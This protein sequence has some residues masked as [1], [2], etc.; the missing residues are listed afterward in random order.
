MV[1]FLARRLAFMVLTMFLLSIAIFAISELAPGNI[2]INTLGNFITPEQ[3]ASFNAQNGLDQP[4]LTRYLRWMVGS[5]WEAERLIGRPIRRVYEENFNRYSW[6]VVA[7]DGTL[8]QNYSP[9]GESMVRVVFQDT[10]TPREEPMGPEVWQPNADGLLVYWGIDTENRAAMWVQGE[11]QVEWVLHAGGTWTD[12]EGAPRA[13]VPLQKGIMRGDPGVSFYTRRPVAETLFSRLINSGYLALL[14]FVF[15]MPLS[16]LLGLVA[17]LNEGKW[18][19]NVLSLGGLITT[20]TP[21]YATGVFLILIFTAWLRLLPG[22]VIVSQDTDIFSNPKMLV[23]PVLT[24]TLIEL[25]YVLRITRASMV[26]VMKTN[27]IRTAV[28]KGLPRLR[29]IFKHALKN[30]L[31]APITVITLHI[32]WLIGGV[33]VVETIFGFPGLGYYILQAALFK[34]L[35]AVEAAAMLL[36]VIAV[37]SQLIAD[38]IYLYLNPRIRYA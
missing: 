20:A 19:D 11:S 29:I 7:E 14:A 34:D 22:A 35:Y 17:G 25:G 31:I 3:E 30:A 5:D 2:A 24:L 28:L 27:F 37:G 12:K 8:Y 10:G 38:I 9:D 4:P 13:Y 36:V 15:I 21:S 16:L 23:L 26:D 32:N 1:K 18:I 6:W 33:V